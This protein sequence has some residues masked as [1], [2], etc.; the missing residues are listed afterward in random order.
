M[1]KNLDSRGREVSVFLVRWH[2]DFCCGWWVVEEVGGGSSA[3]AQSV[4]FWRWG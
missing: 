2:N 1:R 4:A 3:F